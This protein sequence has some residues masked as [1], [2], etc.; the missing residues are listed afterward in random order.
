MVYKTVVL[1]TC[2][3]ARDCVKDCVEN[4][5]KF[6]KD[7]CVVINN[8]IREDNLDDLKSEHV[9][10]VNRKIPKEWITSLIPYHLELWDY[11]FEHNIQSE[12]IITLSSNQLFIKHDIYDFMKDYKAGYW[13]RWLK[14]ETI[15]DIH[16]TC[17]DKSFC[18]SYI[19]DLGR[20]SFIH[21]S[22][23]DGMFYR[24]D[25]FLNMMKYFEDHRG[26][27]INHFSEEFFYPAYLFKNI[28]KDEMAEFSKYNYWTTD[29]LTPEQVDI[30][31]AKGLYI[32]KRVTRVYDDPGRTYIRSLS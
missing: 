9:H 2:H 1:L 31:I 11:M 32:A 18:E 21:Q 6:N 8:G 7:V 14:V 29:F 25:V 24:W 12:Y 23:H 15:A 28:P 30:G 5:F 16:C 26:R 17:E 4:I 22:N 19:D 27:L 13:A 10:V 20:E 3:E